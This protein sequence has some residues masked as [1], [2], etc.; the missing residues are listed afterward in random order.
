MI[1]FGEGWHEREFN[2]V[3]GDQWRWLSRRGEL[4]YF[5]SNGA[6]TLRIRGENP[7]R[8]YSKG[9]RLRVRAGERV[10]SETTVNDDFSIDVQVPPA[11]AW[12]TLTV[13]TDQTHVPADSRWRRSADRR[14]LGLRIY[15][16]EI[17]QIT[18]SAPGTAANSPPAR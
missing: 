4:R 18:A 10:L 17:V 13:E 15:S 14:E 1:G 7:L 11:P 16:C 6:P 9:S 5:A 12:S 8:Y 2:P 3:T